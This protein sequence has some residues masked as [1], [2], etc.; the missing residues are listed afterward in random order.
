V[1]CIKN[2]I[3]SVYRG[4]ELKLM[5]GRLI[6]PLMR[7]CVWWVMILYLGIP[8]LLAVE[9]PSW[10]VPWVVC[11]EWLTGWFEACFVVLCW[12]WC[13]VCAFSYVCFSCCFSGVL[14]MN[15]W[16]VVDNIVWT[17]SW[18]SIASTGC[19]VA[20]WQEKQDEVMYK[21]PTQ[22]SGWQLKSA[23]GVCWFTPENQHRVGAR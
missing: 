11:D 9:K 16:G 23:C 4:R 10:D 14:S 2:S 20:W 22:G 15:S 5:H 19:R 6:E 18:P 1:S 7:Y 17:D 21:E 13:V 8:Y 3:V 12:V